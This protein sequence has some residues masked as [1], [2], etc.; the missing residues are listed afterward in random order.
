MHQ[1]SFNLDSF[2]TTSSNITHSTVDN[3]MDQEPLSD[4]NAARFL[5]QA[6]FSSTKKEI[7]HLKR[8]GINQ[9]LTNQFSMPIGITGYDWLLQQGHN[10][11]EHRYSNRPVDWMSWQ[12]LLSSK[13]TLRKR[14]SL[15]LSEIMVLSCMGLSLP[16]RAFAV[17]AYWDLINK[18]AFGNFRDL[19]KAI[20]TNL[21]MGA[22]LDLRYSR[23]ANDQ[24]RRPDENYA[25]EVMQLFTIGMVE[26]NLDGT[27]KLSGGR[28]IET[29][30]QAT[31][32]NIAQA[33]TGW[34][35]DSKSY[36]IGSDTDTEFARAPMINIPSRHDTRSATFFGVTVPAGANGEQALDI[37]VD[38]LFNHANVAPFI[39]KQLIQ[40]LVSSNPSP[41]YVKRVATIFNSDN[42]GTRGNLKAVFEAILTDKD[43]RN[44]PKRH[45]A[46]IGKVREPMIRLIQWVHTFTN[47]E[48]VSGKWMISETSGRKSFLNQSP[49][50]SS[51][52]F[53]FFDADYA[54]STDAF[55]KNK[56]VAPELQ[57]H[58]VTSTVGYINHIKR[59]IE[60]GVFYG[61]IETITEVMPD[62]S[63]E[64]KLYQQPEKLVAHLNLILCAGQMSPK[65]KGLITSALKSLTEDYPD[66]KKNRIHLAIFMT[67]VSPDY[68]VQR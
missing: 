15:A 35:V 13:D 28:P 59:V 34:T 45:P 64:M 25:R 55:T 14:T 60:K 20:T 7:E 44:L 24:G 49:S 47:R 21:G 42:N 11:K 56:I 27:P 5:Q 48:S 62:Y 37:V 4:I 8:I 68:L 43:A 12:Q 22:Y 61:F 65:T 58:N 33:L 19:L 63:E 3:V 10:T 16:H 26:L 50:R 23:K 2:N 39:C 57:L 17:A 30:N 66:W 67:M 1:T 41:E 51:S 53:N 29:Y 6:Q 36:V 31:V 38:T 40:R 46:T 54:P 9:W 32:S 18:H 52:V